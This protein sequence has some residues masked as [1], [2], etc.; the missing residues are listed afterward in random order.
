M[1]S[2]LLLAAMVAFVPV[3]AFAQDVPE[4]TRFRQ[5][6]ECMAYFAVV[7]GMDGKK[8]VPPA[9]SARLAALG[10]EFMF[11]ASI[12]GYDDDR[13]HTSVV[14]K[15]IEMN[16]II[17]EQGTQALVASHGTMCEAV[18]ETMMEGTGG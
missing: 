10:S 16:T 2:K 15:L 9:V 12:L 6:G 14:E 11:E 5:I 18:V 1:T 7:S 3:Q 8:E 4:A 17:S 13:A